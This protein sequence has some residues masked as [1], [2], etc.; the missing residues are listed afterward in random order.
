M[1]TAKN[2]VSK[3]LNAGTHLVTIDSV[4]LDEAHTD[5]SHADPT[6]QLKIVFKNGEGRF[7]TAWMNLK[8]YRKFEDLTPAEKKSNKFKVDA[9]GYAIDAKKVRLEN[10]ENTKRAQSIIGRIGVDCGIEE[11]EE[12]APEDLIGRELG[13]K[14]EAN[15]Q[16]NLRLVYSMPASKVDAQEEPEVEA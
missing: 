16:D 5:T 8:G 6:P 3:Y 10:V 14:I 1:F 13:I 15:S 7:F 12:F 2:A 9:S 11:G 4:E